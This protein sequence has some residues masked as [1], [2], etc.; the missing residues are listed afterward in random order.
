[1]KTIVF[2]TETTGIDASKDQVIELCIMPIGEHPDGLAQEPRTWRIYPDKARITPEAQEVHGISMED[3]AECPTF[4]LLANELHKIFSEADVYIGYNVQ[5]DIDMVCADFDRV[6]KPLDITGKIIVDPLKLWYQQEKR[7]LEAAHQ[8]FV[9]RPLSGAHA[10]ENDVIATADVLGGMLQ[11]WS[12]K[13]LPWDKLALVCEP[14]RENYVGATNHFLWN[15]AGNVVF[16]FGKHKGE[17]ITKHRGYLNWMLK[18]TF[19]NNVKETIKQI[20]G[21][22]LKKRSENE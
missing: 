16:G 11:E 20:L 17:R 3:L 14:E 10:A 18:G 6:G 13:H 4:A 5:F 22:T 2:D 12:L 1:M 15:E 8:R 7:T 9:G 21:G 19:P